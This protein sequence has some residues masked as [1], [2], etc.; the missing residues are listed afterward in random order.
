M[1][2]GQPDDLED[3]YACEANAGLRANLPSISLAR[4]ALIGSVPCALAA[5]AAIRR[6]LLN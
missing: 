1:T 6:G 4:L 3:W 5:F 2:H